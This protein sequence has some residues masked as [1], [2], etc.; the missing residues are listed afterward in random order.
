MFFHVKID[1]TSLLATPKA[2]EGPGNRVDRETGVCIGMP[3]AKRRAVLTVPSYGWH[4][5]LVVGL[6]RDMIE[7]LLLSH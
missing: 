2:I 7:D 6:Y 1:E 3:R 5:L 4:C